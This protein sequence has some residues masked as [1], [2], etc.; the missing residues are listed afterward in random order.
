MKGNE[1]ETTVNKIV[2]F[3]W[4]RNDTAPSYISELMDICVPFRQ[5]RSSN[6]HLLNIPRT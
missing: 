6:K 4:L 1:N 3:A 2:L 5:L